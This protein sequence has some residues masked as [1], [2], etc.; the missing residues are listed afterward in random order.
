MELHLPAKVFLP[1]ICLAGCATVP[2]EPTN[3]Y[4]SF[5]FE[6]SAYEII[7]IETE[8]G[9]GVNFLIHRQNDKT[10]F[11]AIDVN[12]D[13]VIDRVVAG[14]ISHE[15]AN[16]IYNDGIRQAMDRNQFKKTV[17][18]REFETMHDD[19]RLQVQSYE[20]GRDHYQNRFVIYDS[21][22]IVIGICRD[23]GSDGLLNSLELGE[24]TIDE[25]QILYD[26]ILLRASEMNRI[27]KAQNSRYV[28]NHNK[29]SKASAR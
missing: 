11:R 19:Y 3:T 25:A 21:A 4:F 7:G 14:A 29:P 2:Q 9:G 18:T 1:L 5:D 23:E 12:R 10:L 26:V 16:L 15:R 13:G 28:I 8:D 22:G 20:T 6:D 17:R 24:F 27:E